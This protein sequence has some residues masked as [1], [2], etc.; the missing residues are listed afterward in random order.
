MNSKFQKSLETLE[1][2]HAQKLDIESNFRK[3]FFPFF[4][5]DSFQFLSIFKKT[6]QNIDQCKQFTQRL[7][8]NT[9]LHSLEVQGF[10]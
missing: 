6:V 4:L 2:N 8:H 10:F 3:K 5:F 1:K 9:S 7:A